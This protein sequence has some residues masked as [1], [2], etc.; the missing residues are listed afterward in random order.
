MALMAW[1]A[2]V[3]CEETTVAV[4]GENGLLKIRGRVSKEKIKIKLRMDFETGPKKRGKLKAKFK[5]T[6]VPFRPTLEEDDDE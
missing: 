5:G 2:R 6:F 4:F 3:L 1:K